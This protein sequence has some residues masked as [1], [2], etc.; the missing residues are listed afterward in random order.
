MHGMHDMHS[1]MT[2]CRCSPY[3]LPH[4]SLNKQQQFN[5]NGLTSLL[6]CDCS[7][8]GSLAKQV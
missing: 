8:T 1:K 4:N 6:T 5:W 7:C 3:T 2:S